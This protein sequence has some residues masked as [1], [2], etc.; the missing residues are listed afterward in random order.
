MQ[1][2]VSA[3]RTPSDSV[4][5]PWTGFPPFT[6][7]VPRQYVHRAAVSEVLLTGW[8]PAVDGAAV[9]P[10]AF[11]IRAQWPRGHSLFSQAGGYQDPMLLVESVR[12]IGALLSHAEFDVPFGHH[13][14]MWDM[15]FAITEELLVA[16]PAPTEV[17]LHTVCSDMVRRGKNLSSMRYAVTVVVDGVALG[18]AAAAFRCT[19]PAVHKRLRGERP[20]IAKRAL[21]EP[22]APAAVGRTD[23]AHVVLSAT[24]ADPR[25][26]RWE[27]RVDTGHA[28]FFDHEVDHVPGMLLLEAAR[29]AA[30]ASTGLPYTLV[31]AVDS[32]FHR[33]AELDAPCWIEAHPGLPDASGDI[34]VKIRGTQAEESVFTAVV[35]LRPG[36]R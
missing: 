22:I 31:V 15:S 33:Y 4:L 29:Q 21:G 10:D 18:T 11:V 20:P 23:A 14:L 16:G 24:G 19:S 3:S 30:Q 26:Y 32:T 27:L 7:T 6:T 9:Q 28:I 13:F 8:E 25:A 35:V 34:R 5:T 17:E 12:Q 2:I 1:P 36:R